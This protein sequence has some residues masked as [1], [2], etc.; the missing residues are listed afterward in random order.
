MSAELHLERVTS[1]HTSTPFSR[2]IYVFV[3]RFLLK[4]GLLLRVGSLLLLTSP[5]VAT[6][7]ED[8][9][10]LQGFVESSSVPRGVTQKVL[11]HLRNAERHLVS[12]DKPNS[13][14]NAMSRLELAGRLI[15]KGHPGLTHVV[16][17]GITSRIAQ[18]RGCFESRPTETGTLQVFVEHE[19]SRA[20]N[21]EVYV[22]GVP[23]GT[24]DKTGL[25]KST[26]T[27]GDFVISARRG[28]ATWGSQFVTV[29]PGMLQQVAITLED[30]KESALQ[31]SLSAR[32]A[33]HG[34]IP[35]DSETLTL[36]IEDVY[37]KRIVPN[38]V[39]GVQVDLSGKVFY[40]RDVSSIEDDEVVILLH[41]LRAALDEY[42]APWD[43]SVTVSSPQDA[44]HATARFLPGRYDVKGLITNL[45]AGKR[46]SLT[47]S[48]KHQA[49]GIVLSA[50]IQADGSFEFESL[51]EGSVDFKVEGEDE[52]GG[53]V[54]G[55]AP[56]GLYD[57]VDDLSIHLNDNGEE[58]ISIRSESQLYSSGRNVSS[59]YAGSGPLNCQ[60]PSA[61]GRIASI[62]V[63]VRTPSNRRLPFHVSTRTVRGS[64]CTAHGS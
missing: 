11:V 20:S 12:P 14:R 34:V 25:L 42:A 35:K 40:F 43:L 54:F 48:A 37:G 8:L 6:C 58:V 32:E 3:E 10:D 23:L 51:P 52:N 61:G 60:L 49:T 47:L 53:Y 31:A 64:S 26:V 57:D 46:E 18:V 5:A 9:R 27:T 17:Y 7:L 15:E 22:D 62:N 50:P 39:Y 4:V 19:G 41:D 38:H 28:A 2:G 13:M 24:T 55:L 33:P 63:L 21:A 16:R 29:E 56:L 36:S 59:L 45:E 1:R 30:G 44:Y